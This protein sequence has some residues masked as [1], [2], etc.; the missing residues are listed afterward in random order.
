MSIAEFR[1]RETDE[2]ARVIRVLFEEFAEKH[3]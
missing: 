2:K 3:G 1:V